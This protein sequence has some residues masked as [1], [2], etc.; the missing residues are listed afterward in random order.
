MWNIE[1]VEMLFQNSKEKHA[2][3]GSHLRFMQASH[4]YM[5]IY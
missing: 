2:Q 3:D 4:I 1:H 5:Y